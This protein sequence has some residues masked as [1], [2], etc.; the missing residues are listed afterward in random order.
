MEIIQNHMKYNDRVV[1]VRG[2]FCPGGTMSGGVFV[3]VV[4]VRVVFDSQATQ[5]II[6]KRNP[7]PLIGGNKNLTILH[8]I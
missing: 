8:N 5:N 6:K 1:F 4:F 2:G 3:R 7:I